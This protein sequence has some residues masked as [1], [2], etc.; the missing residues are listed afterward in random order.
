LQ[1][2]ILVSTRYQLVEVYRRSGD[3]WLYRA[4]HS[5]DIIELH[6]VDLQI[7]VQDVYEDTTVALDLETSK[8]RKKRT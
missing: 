5:G 1:E 2:Y 3:E 6:S 8:Q 7:P 4:Y